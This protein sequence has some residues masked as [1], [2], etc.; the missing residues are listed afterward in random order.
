M[1]D[2][3]ISALATV[4]TPTGV[5]VVPIVNDNTTKKVDLNTLFSKIPGDVGYTGLRV[6]NGTPETVG[7]SGAI[8]VV[9]EYT[10]VS[11]QSGGSMVL[12][13]ANGVHGQ[14]KKLICTAAINP[15]TIT[16]TQSAFTSIVFN[17]IGQTVTLEYLTNKWYIISNYGATIN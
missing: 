10:Y 6:H 16:A 15:S 8:S 7:A 17:A 4:S 14:I 11:N 5:D 13:L 12:T 2:K 1:T 3:A 9:T